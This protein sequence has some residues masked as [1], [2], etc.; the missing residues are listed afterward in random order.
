[1]NIKDPILQA[2]A[3]VV[4]QRLSNLQ[5]D[6]TVTC[7]II[8]NSK[9]ELGMYTVEYANKTK[10]YAYSDIKDYSNGTTV[11]VLIPN[12]DWNA[13]KHILGKQDTDS[14]MPAMQYIHPMDT[15]A[16]YDVGTYGDTAIISA[17][18]SSTP[19]FDE[20]NES[21]PYQYTLDIPYYYEI[22]N[23][24]FNRTAHLTSAN[25]LGDP[26]D[27]PVPQKISVRIQAPSGGNIIVPYTLEE[28]AQIPNEWQ[29]FIEEG[30]GQVMWSNAQVTYGL[31]LSSRDNE[32]L[33]I[34]TTSK[35][36][37]S[38]TS[39]EPF[40]ATLKALW[41]NKNTNN[42]YIG[43]EDGSFRDKEEAQTILS[44]D[45][46]DA[47]AIYYWLQ[48][49]Q[50]DYGESEW[51]E[52]SSSQAS[53]NPSLDT[54]SIFIWEP[55]E[56]KPQTQF[57][58][59]L[60]KNGVEFTSNIITF[61]S[62]EYQASLDN[63]PLSISI[64]GETDYFNSYDITGETSQQGPY[65]FSI[66]F[67]G[68]SEETVEQ[69]KFYEKPVAWSI[70]AKD[71]NLS[72]I[73]SINPSTGEIIIKKQYN[74]ATTD[75]DNTIIAQVNIL[76]Q[77][78]IA[79]KVLRF[80]TI[81]QS[82]NGYY[83]YVNRENKQY[84][85]E[86]STE[87]ENI[88]STL[89]YDVYKDST[90][91]ER[92]RTQN[93]TKEQ[94]DKLFVILDAPPVNNEI[95]ARKTVPLA[96][97]TPGYRYAG[98]VNVLYDSYGTRAGRQ[99]LKMSLYKDNQ[100]VENAQFKFAK[101]SRSGWNIKEDN[102]LVA[103]N[104]YIQQ[105][106]IIIEIFDNNELV[107][108]QGVVVLQDRYGSQFIK[109][110]D[111]NLTIDHNNK[112][113][114]SAMIG[115]GSKNSDG[116]FTGVFMGDVKKTRDNSTVASGLLGY[117][118]GVQTFGFNTNG[119]AFIGGGGKG[120]ISFDGDREKIEGSGSYWDLKEGVIASNDFDKEHKGVQLN[121]INGT[122]KASNF[123]LKTITSGLQLSSD[124]IFQLMPNSKCLIDVNSN[125]FIIQSYDFDTYKQLA[126]DASEAT[127][128]ITQQVM[129]FKYYKT[130]PDKLIYGAEIRQG[131]G[132]NYT[133]YADT[134]KGDTLYLY[135]SDDNKYIRTSTSSYPTEKY[136]S[137][138]NM[139]EGRWYKVALV[140]NGKLIVENGYCY[141]WSNIEN[142]LKYV[143]TGEAGEYIE[144]TTITQGGNTS[145]PYTCGKID[146][147]NG[148]MELYNQGKILT[149]DSD[150]LKLNGKTIQ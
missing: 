72:M 138:F 101:S 36:T 121:F 54:D 49:F 141:S 108:R 84:D 27:L 70:G 53:D 77:T 118:D 28:D 94:Y 57:K 149:F 146:L 48:W 88:N 9:R 43:F 125:N 18:V 2:I 19:V 123:E 78:Y 47:D 97:G 127:E 67:N 87:G 89:L 106:P 148:T 7:K 55:L 114:M 107:W 90:I 134:Q 113:I 25:V 24:R 85:F 119:T 79:K 62:E 98:P 102:V 20:N 60:Y 96:I 129:K 10:F 39:E 100:L 35:L 1:M 92:R 45:R 26:C 50:K 64:E 13:Q 133:Q 128:E 61:T 22:E 112:S 17:E 15:I 135:R 51:K 122:I 81:E 124:G 14:L 136:D 21:K 23:K 120:R 142:K 104:M 32:T 11:Y 3:T 131:P 145:W 83:I 44:T 29:S 86:F 33:E 63:P 73:Q 5:F 103:P 34:A 144:T 59:C 126:L 130:D 139:S 46:P 109:D 37:I 30:G 140:R 117:K 95:V 137:K 6:N 143:S 80:S 16:V 42:T 58:A 82:G 56:I 111:G 38:T 99:V 41:I 74:P 68:W 150:G 66:K 71:S 115:A 116:S 65:Q 52:V 93:L 132:T 147:K 40:K 31:D 69:L 105:D 75:E 91:I 110:W 4:D 8:D 76:G 12:G